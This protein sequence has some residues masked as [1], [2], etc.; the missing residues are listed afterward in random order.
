MP[1]GHPII[2]LKSNK[3]NMAAVSVK[4]STPLFLFGNSGSLPDGNTLL[5]ADDIIKLKRCILGTKVT[6][7]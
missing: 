6:I 4:T 5:E 2:L 1:P 3:L 7:K